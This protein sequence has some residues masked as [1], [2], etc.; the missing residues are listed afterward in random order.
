MI[1][2]EHHL[3]LI[4]AV[5]C[6]NFS[7]PVGCS[8]STQTLTVVS[9]NMHGFNQGFSTVRDLCLSIKTD[10]FLLQEHWLTPA[11]LHKFDLTF[12]EYFTFGFS[13]MNSHVESGVLRGRPYGGL[14]IM[15]KNDL[16]KVTRTVFASDRYVIVKVLNYLIVNVYFPCAGTCDRLNIID[17]MISEISVHLCNFTDC[18]ILVGGDFNCDLDGSDHISNKIN[19]FLTEQNLRRCDQISECQKTNTYVNEALNC[20]SCLDYFLLSVNEKLFDFK[21]ID[22]GSNLSDHL[23]VVVKCFYENID[24]DN[25]KVHNTQHKNY[26]QTFLRW[27]YAD[28]NNYYLLTGQRLQYILDEF[29]SKET[30]G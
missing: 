20:G 27:D 28:I 7:L 22:E 16:R 25:H 5:H 2:L 14:M 15:I 24:S 8:I 13:A 26:N 19:Q 29:I 3:I 11:N 21:V 17:A 18:I 9:Y 12:P 6:N 23:P 30:L 1:F 10:I 4:M